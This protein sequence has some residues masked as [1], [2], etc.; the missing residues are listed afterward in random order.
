[1]VNETPFTS[2]M[3][4]W[5]NGICF[6]VSNNLNTLRVSHYHEDE[7][8][9]NSYVQA[10][11]LRRRTKQRVYKMVMCVNIMFLVIKLKLKNFTKTHLK[12]WICKVS[13]K[14]MEK[15]E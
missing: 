7:K 8:F 12:E 4:S 10:A 6:N 1:M 2:F 3:L 11:V 14:V 5:N 15:T 13:L 9:W